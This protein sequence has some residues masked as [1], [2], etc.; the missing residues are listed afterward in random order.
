MEQQELIH[1]FSSSF[2]KKKVLIPSPTF[3]EYEL[4][5]KRNN[6]QILYSQVKK[7]FHIDSEFIVKKSNNP[8]SWNNYN[9]FMQ[10][11]QSYRKGFKKTNNRNFRKN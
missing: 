7:D 1:Y 11:K 3:C 8:K 6:A 5:S 10:S 4:A 2:V 9:F